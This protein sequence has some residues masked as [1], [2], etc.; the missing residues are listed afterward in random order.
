MVVP[1]AA[2]DFHAPGGRDSEDAPTKD[3]SG[4]GGS[5]IVNFPLSFVN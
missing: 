5:S 4:A 2:A 1:P 3:E